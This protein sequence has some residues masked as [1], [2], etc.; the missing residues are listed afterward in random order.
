VSIRRWLHRVVGNDTEVVVEDTG[1]VVGDAVTGLRGSLPRG[2]RVVV[3]NTGD[4][5]ATDGSTAVSGADYDK[6]R[7][8]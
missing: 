2:A 1:D 7:K 8:R 4:A 5:V 3:R 6:E